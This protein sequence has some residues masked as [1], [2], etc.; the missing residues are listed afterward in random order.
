MPEISRFFGIKIF[1]HISEHP[2]PHFH[3]QYGEQW[4]AV[5][6]LTLEAM[7]GKISTRALKMVREWATIH[8]SE[9]LNNWE[10]ARKKTA[11]N[12]IEPLE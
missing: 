6:I 2:P 1:M 7:A 4:V 8:Q 5:N 12:K 10:L 11:L 9:L 3:A